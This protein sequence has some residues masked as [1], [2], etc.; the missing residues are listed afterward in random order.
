M[1]HYGNNTQTRAFPKTSIVT[2]QT[3]EVIYSP[4]TLAVGICILSGRLVSFISVCYL[5]LNARSSHS[6]G[7]Y[8]AKVFDMDFKTLYFNHYYVLITIL[9]NAY[10]IVRFEMIP[11]SH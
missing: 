9:I 11:T 1:I 4:A 8:A 7:R 5:V 6:Q 3:K 2:R 10:Y